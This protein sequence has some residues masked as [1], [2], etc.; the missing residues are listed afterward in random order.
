MDTL[1]PVVAK[2]FDGMDTTPPAFC[3]SPN[4]RAPA[5]MASNG[6][7][8]S[9]DRRADRLCQRLYCLLAPRRE[10]SNS[11]QE[12]W[13]LL[14]Y[15]YTSRALRCGEKCR[16]TDRPR[17]FPPACPAALKS[18][19]VRPRA[20]AARVAFSSHVGGDHGQRHLAVF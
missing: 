18:H 6:I 4:V 7:P 14:C 15:H 8:C 12:I 19:S 5:G 3:F 9:S 20:F 2:I 10:E 16:N 11:P 17:I 1:V 13:R